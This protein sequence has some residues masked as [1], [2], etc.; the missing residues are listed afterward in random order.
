MQNSTITSPRRGQRDRGSLDT[1]QLHRQLD[2]P[3][4]N[5]TSLQC[6]V[7]SVYITQWLLKC[8]AITMNISI[9]PEQVKVLHSEAGKPLDYVDQKFSYD[10]EV[11][12]TENVRNGKYDSFHQKV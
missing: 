6:T 2:F 10:V 7:F 4:E 3:T 1:V 11:E 8:C 5:C 12:V 9:S